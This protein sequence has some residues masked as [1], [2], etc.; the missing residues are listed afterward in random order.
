MLNCAISRYCCAFFHWRANSPPLRVLASSAMP[1]L[2]VVVGGE[3]AS[4]AQLDVSLLGRW[5]T[6]CCSH[7]WPVERNGEDLET[8][9][10]QSLVLRDRPC[11][12]QPNRLIVPHV[13]V[14]ITDHFGTDLFPS[15]FP[16]LAIMFGIIHVFIQRYTKY[17]QSFRFLASGMM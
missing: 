2:L 1:G 8:S 15:R 13:G 4:R 7:Y 10:R 5:R 6:C 17:T 11:L 9:Q 14:Y 12:E 16:C 3:E